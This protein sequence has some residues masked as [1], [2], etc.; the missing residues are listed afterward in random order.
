MASEIIS[1]NEYTDKVDVY[2]FDIILWDF[3][4]EEPTYNKMNPKDAK[5]QKWY[6]NFTPPFNERISKD[7]WKLIYLW[8]HSDTVKFRAFE[9]IMKSFK[10]FYQKNNI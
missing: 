1:G 8:W 3:F 7:F 4:S 6:Y 2:S 10:Y 5:H 9:K